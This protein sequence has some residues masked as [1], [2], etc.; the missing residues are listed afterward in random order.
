VFL[1]PDF[2]YNAGISAI[3]SLIAVN[4]HI[5]HCACAK[6]PYFYF[7]SK[8]WRHHRVP[9]HRFPIWHAIFGDSWTF[10][11]DIAFLIF[12]W[13]F[14]TSGS[15]MGVLGGKIGKGWCDIDPNKL[16]LTFRCLYLC[17][18]FREN[19]WRVPTDAQT[20]TGFII[21]HM[22]YAIAIAMG[23]IKMF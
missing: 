3:L 5:F 6:R 22:L 4:F 11:A 19:R 13:I 18:Q 8:I 15:K 23:Q 9:R 10:K 1:D 7:Q 16:V 14:R 2:L 20:Q 12:A 21:C 17:V